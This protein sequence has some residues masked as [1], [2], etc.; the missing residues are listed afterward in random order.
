VNTPEAVFLYLRKG[1]GKARSLLLSLIMS[2]IHNRARPP[3]SPLAPTV[4][5]PGPG[6]RGGE[7]FTGKPGSDRRTH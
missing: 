2:A 5:R 4:A 1:P 7:G 6:S 3:T